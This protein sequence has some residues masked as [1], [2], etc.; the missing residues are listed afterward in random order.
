MPIPLPEAIFD[1]VG[2]DHIGPLPTTAA[3]NRYN[4]VAIGYLSKFMEVTAVPSL[5]TSFIISFLQHRF[6]WRHGLPKK[7]ISD[8]ATTF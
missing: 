4:L 2:T 1:T 8:R 7:L 6:E 5:A 3:G